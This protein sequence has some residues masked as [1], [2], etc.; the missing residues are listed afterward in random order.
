MAW[1]IASWSKERGEGTVVAP[2]LG[3][4]RFGPKENDRGVTDYDV[5]EE[6]AVDPHALYIR[7]NLENAA[8]NEKLFEKL[9]NSYDS[10]AALADKDACA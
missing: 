10:A 3:P 5:G 8:A 9:L 1:K 2:H 6:V 4:Y 7:I